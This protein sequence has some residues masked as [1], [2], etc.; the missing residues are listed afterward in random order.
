MEWYYS[1]DKTQLGPVPEDE[2]KAKIAS[3][4]VTGEDMV[5]REGMPDWRRVAAVSELAPPSRLGPQSAGAVPTGEVPGV[6]PYQP[7]Y[8]GSPALPTQA[9]LS[10]LSIASLV[11]G[12]V[13]LLTCTFLPGIAAVVCG[14]MALGR[15]PEQGA[16]PNERGM[17]IAGLVMGYLSVAVLALVTLMVL[18]AFA[19]SVAAA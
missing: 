13:G 16:N 10:G 7:P 9:A 17:A 11:C 8:A 15:I 14:H 6:A 12:L 2:L 3:G 19:S 5:W 18:F 1:K 4:E